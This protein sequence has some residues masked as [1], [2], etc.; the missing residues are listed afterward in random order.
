MLIQ[1]ARKRRK[2]ELS[3]NHTVDRS[4]VHRDSIAEVLL[5][6]IV[7]TGRSSFEVGA[8]WP[9]SHRVYRPDPAGRHD[10]MLLL[11][12]IRQ[13]GLALSHHAFGV[14]YEFRSIMHDI[15]FQL[16]PETEP[17][18]LNRATN[19]AIAVTCDNVQLRAGRLRRMTITLTMSADDQEFAVGTGTLSWLPVRTFQALRARNRRPVTVP[20]APNGALTA[21]DSPFRTAEDALLCADEDDLG[22][23]RLLIRLDHPVY[24]DH[25]LD[26][27]PGMM[28]VDAVWQ[29]AS[30]AGPPG[31]RLVMCRMEC[32]TFTELIAETWI[33]VAF[34][35]PDS[36]QFRVEQD[37]A[38][39]AIG[40]M[41][42]SVSI[43]PA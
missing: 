3:W 1:D 35:G 32:P 43:P 2:T 20:D 18:A 37:G 27:V 36:V 5:T 22:R 34:T 24:F 15:G 7:R 10:P 33:E 38:P 6:D 17:R 29:A 14:P 4:L 39:T 28:L 13:T 12:T 41:K 42:L 16:R 26:H 25:P 23:R 30:T 8:Q 19:V 31:S 40:I 11:E 9:R 21:A